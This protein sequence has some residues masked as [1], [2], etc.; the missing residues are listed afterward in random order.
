MHKSNM[1]K[2]Q[3]KLLHQPL[4]VR[5]WVNRQGFI[6]FFIHLRSYPIY[7][8][9]FRSLLSWSY[10]LSCL[11]TDLAQLTSSSR[12]FATHYFATPW[13][14]CQNIQPWAPAHPCLFSSAMHL[15]AI[16]CM[17]DIVWSAWEQC[18]VICQKCWCWIINGH[19]NTGRTRN[20]KTWCRSSI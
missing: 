4:T 17:A 10:H 15:L 2:C 14:K 7:L 12:Y 18:E 13:T 3:S 1:K 16:M 20:M 5:K 6:F 11:I 19:S 9:I 8:V